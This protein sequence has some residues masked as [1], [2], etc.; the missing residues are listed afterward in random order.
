MKSLPLRIHLPLFTYTLGE[1]EA[2]GHLASLYLPWHRPCASSSHP[3]A[4]SGEPPSPF[5]WG[6]EKNFFLAQ[7]PPHIH[8][9]RLELPGQTRATSSFASITRSRKTPRLRGQHDVSTCLARQERGLQHPGPTAGNY[10][11]LLKSQANLF[12]LQDNQTTTLKL[13]R[14]QSKPSCWTGLS[15]TLLSSFFCRPVLVLYCFGH[16]PGLLSV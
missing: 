5:L 2:K 7:P 12:M 14:G 3:V 4:Q 10:V 1:E 16:G 8:A 9:Q 6:P 15:E 11:P 13:P